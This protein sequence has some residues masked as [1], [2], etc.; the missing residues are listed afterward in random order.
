MLDSGTSLSRTSSYPTLVSL[1]ESLSRASLDEYF[2]GSGWED[3]LLP[4]HHRRRTTLDQRV[5][6]PNHIAPASRRSSSLLNPPPSQLLQLPLPDV[7]PALY[8][9]AINDLLHPYLQALRLVNPD[10][11]LPT[12]LDPPTHKKSF[13]LH[14]PAYSDIYPVVPARKQFSLATRLSLLGRSFFRWTGMAGDAGLSPEEIPILRTEDS[15]RSAR[16]DY[17]LFFFWVCPL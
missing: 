11:K 16:N 5:H 6:R 4:R 15:R 12:N 2:T 8:V 10:T 17:M 1:G 14:L 9:T 7:N 13:D 3:L